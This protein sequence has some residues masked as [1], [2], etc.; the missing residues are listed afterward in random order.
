MFPL[1]FGDWCPLREC[2]LSP[3]AIGARYGYILSWLAHRF[4]VPAEHAERAAGVPEVVRVHVVVG[5]SDGEVV[6]GGRVELD[7]THVSAQVQRHSALSLLEVPNLYL[8]GLTVKCRR[9]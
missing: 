7:A 6:A 3:S 5:R 8:R 1:P 2:S 9:P 4:G